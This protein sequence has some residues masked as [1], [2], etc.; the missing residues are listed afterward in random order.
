[1]RIEIVFEEWTPPKR[2]FDQYGKPS[3]PMDQYD[4]VGGNYRILRLPKNSPYLKGKKIPDDFKGIQYYGMSKGGENTSIRRRV[5]DHCNDFRSPIP[6]DSPGGLIRQHL[7]GD[8]Y[9]NLYYQYYPISQESAV[10]YKSLYEES[11]IKKD[12]S[13]LF[14]KKEQEHIKC[15]EKKNGRRPLGHKDNS[16]PKTKQIREQMKY[17]R[18]QMYIKNNSK[19]STIKLDTGDIGKGNV[20]NSGKTE[21]EN[22]L[23]WVSKVQNLQ[24]QY[25][26][27][28]SPEETEG[29][30]YDI[31]KS[32]KSSFI[33]D[34]SKSTESNKTEE[35]SNSSSTPK[36]NEELEL[37]KKL[38]HL[39][40]PENL[41]KIKVDNKT[42]KSKRYLTNDTLFWN[43]VKNEP[44]SKVKNA[45]ADSK[46]PLRLKLR[47][48]KAE[49]IKNLARVSRGA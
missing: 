4:S 22:T 44:L 33:N 8:E 35:K 17:E 16:N 45:F 39:E 41:I 15:Y 37:K 10:E 31:V 32:I 13:D 29:I 26:E 46:H 5:C 12:N 28:F 48:K 40:I 24:A 14:L 42:K 47:E 11:D 2:C 23:E 25:H 27:L 1:M 43:V 38:V 9:D 36:S 7:G 21:I 3:I 6:V 34:L 19:N 18:C 30:S 20:V 49:R